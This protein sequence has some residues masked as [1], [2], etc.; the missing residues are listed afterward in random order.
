MIDWWQWWQNDDQQF[1]VL[2]Q[3]VSNFLSSSPPILIQGIVYCEVCLLEISASEVVCNRSVKKVTTCSTEH[4]FHQFPQKIF[5][6]TQLTCEHN[7]DVV[8]T[9]ESYNKQPVSKSCIPIVS[10]LILQIR[11]GTKWVPQWRTR[12]SGS[13]SQWG[14]SPRWRTWPTSRPGSADTCTTPSSRTGTW[15]PRG[16]C[17]SVYE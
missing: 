17:W 13:R 10:I 7:S 16:E 8:M 2:Y 5:E 9:T 11:L 15:L 3:P 12:T 14:A 6:R 4:Y 1:S